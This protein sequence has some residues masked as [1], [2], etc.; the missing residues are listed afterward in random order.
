MQIKN[1]KKYL[2]LQARTDQMCEH[3]HHCFAKAIQINHEDIQVFNL[4]ENTIS[5]DI[6]KNYSGILFGGSGEFSVTSI[7]KKWLDNILN[8][9]NVIIKHDIPMFGSCFGHQLLALAFNAKV[10]TQEHNKEVGTFEVQI[11]KDGLS[12]PIFE[13]FPQVFSVQLGHQ[14]FVTE[15]PS[16]CTL[17]SS[18]K[19]CS[20]QCFQVKGKLIYTTQFHPELTYE[21]MATRINYYADYGY[22]DKSSSIEDLKKSFYDTPISSNILF[23]FHK[24]VQ[25]KLTI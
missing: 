7:D 12:N 6:L 14:D 23:N 4:F 20:N 19:K 9:I 15:V 8:I 21:D 10:E 24:L 18:S 2:L 22:V 25:K 5:F 17:L 1:F 11:N 3:E 16:E 13:G